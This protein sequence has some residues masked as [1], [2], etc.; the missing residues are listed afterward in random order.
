MVIKIIASIILL[1]A[2]FQNK[3]NAPAIVVTNPMMNI[4]YKGLSN[5][6]EALI[7]NTGNK[8]I[9]LKTDN[10]TIEKTVDNKFTITPEKL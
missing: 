4:L 8:K 5:Q 2:S 10:G 9:Q 3:S 7:E 6:L 1:I